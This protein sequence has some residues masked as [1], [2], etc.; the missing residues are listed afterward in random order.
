M[1]SNL[2][3]SGLTLITLS[4]NKKATNPVMGRWPGCSDAKINY[5]SFIIMYGFD[6]SK[7]KI[8]PFNDFV[9]KY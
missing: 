5:I 9:I 4:P 1:S 3:V 8:Y 6:K 2:H 7:N